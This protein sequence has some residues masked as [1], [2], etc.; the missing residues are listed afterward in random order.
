MNPKDK[1]KHALTIPREIIPY[2]ERSM[3][4]ILERREKRMKKKRGADLKKKGE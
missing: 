4:E 1:P 2:H 3:Q